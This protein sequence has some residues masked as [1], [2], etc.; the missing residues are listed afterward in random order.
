MILLE[1]D[2]YVCLLNDFISYISE[3]TNSTLVRHYC[4][5]RVVKFSMKHAA[6]TMMNTKQQML[7]SKPMLLLVPVN[8]ENSSSVVIS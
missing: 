1:E 3:V 2:G 8:I 6:L 5:K 4:S 7:I